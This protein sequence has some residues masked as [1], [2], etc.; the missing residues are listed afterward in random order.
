MIIKE[1][2]MTNTIDNI[3]T[4]KSRKVLYW[5]A[6]SLASLVLTAIGVSDIVHIPSVIEGLTKL[7]Y[8]VYFAMIIGVWQLLGVTALL[9]PG[10]SRLKEWA[11]AGFFFTLTGASVSHAIS[12]DSVGHILFPLLLLSVLAVSWALLPTRVTVVLEERPKIAPIV[13]THAY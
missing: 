2:T 11:Y 4:T 12:G 5:L 7:G 3:K 6:T 10:F 1:Q 13:N 8:P 9:V